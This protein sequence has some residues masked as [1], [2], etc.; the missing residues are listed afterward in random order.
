MEQ[1]TYVAGPFQEAWQ[2]EYRYGALY[3]F[4]PHGVI[5]PVDELRRT[6]DPKS[7]SICRAHI[8]LSE[9]FRQPLTGAHVHELRAALASVEPFEISYGPL[10]S[11]PPYPGVVYTITPEDAFMELRSRVHATAAFHNSPFKRRDRAPHMTI[12]EFITVE[13]TNALLQK[14]QGQ[15]PEGSFVCDS[16]EYAIPNR[17]FYFERV[18]TLPLGQ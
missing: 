14:L 5:E 17:D 16:I 10:R 13:E 1:F 8:S 3:I 18:L 4:P 15:V 11:F 7:D 6:Y 12:A 2:D 9:P